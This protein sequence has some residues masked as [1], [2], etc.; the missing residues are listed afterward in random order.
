M[1]RSVDIELALPVGRETCRSGCFPG[2]CS[3]SKVHRGELQGH[4]CKHHLWLGARGSPSR[5]I[6][7]EGFFSQCPHKA[8]TRWVNTGCLPG[9]AISISG[10]QG[11]GGGGTTNRREGR[12]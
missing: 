4:G 8:A 7:Q 9:L 10:L 6:L 12:K 11:G 5:G 1:E 2:D 3:S